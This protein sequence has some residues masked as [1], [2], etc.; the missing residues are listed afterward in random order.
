[1]YTNSKA[2]RRGY[3]DGANRGYDDR[4]NGGLAN[5]S[6]R[7]RPKNARDDSSECFRNEEDME[8]SDLDSEFSNDLW[9]AGV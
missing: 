7:K 4:E 5:R 2:Q 8:D 6:Y 9:S 1:M 3:I